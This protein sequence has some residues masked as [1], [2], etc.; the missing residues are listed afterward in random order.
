MVDQPLERGAHGLHVRSLER[1]RRIDAREPRR[2]EQAVALAQREVQRA[3]ELEHHLSAGEG[4]P[5]FE[6]AQ[7]ALR[8]VGLDRQLE[9]G[10]TPGAA[11]APQQLAE[12]RE[13]GA[14]SGYGR[15]LHAAIL[16]PAGPAGHYLP[17]N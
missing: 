16:P 5:G 10:E 14:R 12:G 17:G 1:P 11:R 7:M 4:A 9:L 3:R 2:Y 6:E 15:R 8:D 13:L